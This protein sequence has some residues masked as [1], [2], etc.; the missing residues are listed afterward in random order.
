MTADMVSGKQMDAIEAWLQRNPG[1]PKIL[2][3][4]SVFGLPEEELIRDPLLCQNADGWFGYPRSWKRLAAFIA[5]NRIRNVIFLSGDYHLS[6]IADLQIEAVG[7]AAPVRA[8]SVVCSGWNATL[9]FANRRCREIR[10]GERVR[11]P[12]SGPEVDMWSTAQVL[13][14]AFRQFSKL[15]LV[16]AGSGW[17]LQVRVYGPGNEELARTSRLL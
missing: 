10:R 1:Q 5:L 13:S 14:D 9:P 8:L 15:T 17:E 12:L 16:P 6:A 11:A 2:C 3:C 4:G 7:A